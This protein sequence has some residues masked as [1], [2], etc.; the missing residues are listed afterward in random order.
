MKLH[1]K[2][3]TTDLSFAFAK[4][5]I[6]CSS[7]AISDHGYFA[8][9]FSGGS[10]A[11]MVCECFKQAEFSESVDWSK[12]KIF[13]CDERYVDL[14][15]PDSN[16]KSIY[17]GLIVKHSSILQEN[18]FKMNKLSSLEEAALDYE[19]Q[20]KTVFV[21]DGFPCFDLL[22]LGMGPDGHICSLFP[23]HEL[24]NEESKWVSY[25]DDS[26]KPPP[27]RIT[28]TLNVVNNASCVLFVVTGESKAE[29]VK[30]IVENPPTRSI[31][32]SLVKPIH[33]N[34]HWF[35]DTAAAS[36]LSK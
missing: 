34:V 2:S 24:L 4:F 15:D 7:K 1:V 33:K 35:M 32:A 25:L 9:G 28:F 8:V 20:M 27:Q 29:K 6:E 11:T 36:L 26:P 30:E 10:A 18:V 5:L 22:V 14:S 3:S 21:T 31:P 23:N 12:W 16:F 19:E 13:I 17:D